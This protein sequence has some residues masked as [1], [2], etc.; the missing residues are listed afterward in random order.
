MALQI[1]NNDGSITK[2]E[3]GQFV[4]ITGDDGSVGMVFFQVPGMVIQI[5][6]GSADAHRYEEMF[7]GVGVKLNK[8]LIQRR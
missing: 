2:V 7:R 3:T 5:V 4:E 6:P 1:R 8:V